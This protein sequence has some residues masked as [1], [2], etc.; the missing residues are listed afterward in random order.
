MEY[1][2]S[3][4][5]SSSG[6]DLSPPDADRCRKLEAA[7][8]PEQRH[9]LLQHGTEAPFCGALLDNKEP[10]TY[11]CGLCGLPL[12]RSG[13]N[14]RPAPAGPVSRHRLTSLI[15]DSRKTAASA[16]SARRYSAP[17]AEAISV[18]CFPMDHRRPVFASV[19]T[20]C[21][22]SSSHKTCRCLTSSIEAKGCGMG[23]DGKN[24]PQRSV[25][26][27]AAVCRPSSIQC[28]RAA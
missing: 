9:V 7:L 28:R 27:T 20:R 4:T 11:C 8:T 24:G 17:D 14:S 25:A 5:R 21:R 19:S 3:S 13:R 23:D 6:F 18:M 2:S 26:M 10:G 15:S 22:L 12:F 16:W 1:R